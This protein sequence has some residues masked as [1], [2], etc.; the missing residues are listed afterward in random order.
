MIRDDTDPWTGATGAS[1]ALPKPLGW[2][3]NWL[4]S[5]RF[6]SLSSQHDALW[7]WVAPAFDDAQRAAPAFW[8][9]HLDRTPKFVFVYHPMQA[10][11]GFWLAPTERGR[12][13]GAWCLTQGLAALPDDKNTLVMARIALPNDAADKTCVRAGL[14]VMARQAEH[15]IYAYDLPR[16]AS[17]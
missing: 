8:V 5:A 4:P 14:R 12:N 6:Q 11:F 17:R 16:S 10:Q 7:A 1:S 2:S 9:M 15:I 3:A 13:F